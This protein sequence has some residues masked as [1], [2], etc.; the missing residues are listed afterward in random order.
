MDNHL[1]YL[2]K[3][4]KIDLNK[5][6][7]KYRIFNQE[8]FYK[9]KNEI[10]IKIVNGKYDNLEQD[11]VTL[12]KILKD[13]NLN[14]FT[15]IVIK[16][17]SLFVESVLLNTINKDYEISFVKLIEA[18][19]LT[20]PAFT[21]DNYMNFVYSTFE[22]RLLMNIALIKNKLGY[23]NKSID[24][25]TFCLD[26]LDPE[27]AP[28]RIRILY[29]LAY[30]FHR[31]DSHEKALYYA[32]EGINLSVENNNLAVLA[33]LYSRKG[34]AEFFLK[35]DNYTESFERAIHIHDILNQVNLKNMLFSFCKTHN[36]S[37]S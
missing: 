17:L 13:S 10:E 6:M 5:I 25:L 2:S 12:K 23:T 8:E 14:L 22:I 34:V 31:I 30:S 37:I 26:N 36:I 16:Q 18:I 19:Q 32:N 21:V 28:L 24:I 15:S 29:N 20:T 7:L 11:L 35:K 33:L 4:L 27:E 1:E 3:A 9:T